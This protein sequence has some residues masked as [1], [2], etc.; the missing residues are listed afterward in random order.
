MEVFVDV[1]NN[2]INMLVMWEF[3]HKNVSVMLSIDNIEENQYNNL[4]S[5]QLQVNFKIKTLIVHIYFIWIIV[6]NPII[7]P[8]NSADLLSKISVGCVKSINS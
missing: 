8:I 1:E 4:I 3:A 7:W 5:A 6:K 2:R